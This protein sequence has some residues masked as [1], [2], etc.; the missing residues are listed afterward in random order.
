MAINSCF[1]SWWFE[2]KSRIPNE[3]ILKIYTEIQQFLK[4]N[5]NHVTQVLDRIIVQL[6]V[7][8]SAF[9]GY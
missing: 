8:A 3:N 9:R 1:S 6:F 2:H 7:A 5:L 4:A